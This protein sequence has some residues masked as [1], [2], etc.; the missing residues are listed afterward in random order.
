MKSA[1]KKSFGNRCLCKTE[2]ETCLSEV[3][4]SINSRPLTFVGTDVENKV[5][6]TP[7]HFLSGQGNQC[8]ENKLIEDPEGVTLENLSLRHQEMLLREE[9]FW[10]IWSKEY[11]RNLPFAYQRFK[12]QGNLQIGSVVLI[13]E[14]NL[15]RMKW[16]L[17]VVEKLHEGRDG[18][19][20]AVDL[21]TV[22]GRKTRA[23]QRLH[24]L[25]ISE[26]EVLVEENRD[27]EVEDCSSAE[28]VDEGVE[29]NDDVQNDVQNDV[30]NDSVLV[31]GGISHVDMNVKTRAG[32]KTK[33]PKR[34]D[35][36]EMYD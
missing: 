36:F 7:N 30:H 8:L 26:K 4:A 16:L 29:G 12:K 13:R 1:I 24:D 20:R 9:D 15:P 23:V 19:P 3:A 2:L 34:F 32:R 27:V 17:G 18:I 35:D 11:I 10:K 14:D 6:L 21:R 31:D 33:L 22:H 25:E 28:V 5:P